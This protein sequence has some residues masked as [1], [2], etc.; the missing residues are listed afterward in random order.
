MDKVS[1]NGKIFTYFEYAKEHLFKRLEV[2]E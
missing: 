2:K 1:F